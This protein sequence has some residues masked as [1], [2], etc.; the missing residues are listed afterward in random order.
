LD[1][2]LLTDTEMALGAEKWQTFDNPFSDWADSI[3]TH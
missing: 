3:A 2:C 1:A